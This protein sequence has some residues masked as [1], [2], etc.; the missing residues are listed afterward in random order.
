MCIF[1]GI[2]IFNYCCELAL[3]PPTADGANYVQYSQA[4]YT[5]KYYYKG[6]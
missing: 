3:L 4:I 2:R 1:T 5:N 6:N